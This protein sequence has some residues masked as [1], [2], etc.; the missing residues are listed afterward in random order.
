MLEE[1]KILLG[2]VIMNLFQSTALSI[3]SPFYPRIAQDKGIN[4]IMIG[5]IFAIAPFTRFLCSF[6]VGIILLKL[7]RKKAIIISTFIVAGSFIAFSLVI[8]IDDKVNFIVVSMI[9]RSLQ[10]VGMSFGMTASMA[11]VGSVFKEN[12]QKS[13]SIIETVNGLGNIIGPLIGALFYFIG[14]FMCPFMVGCIIIK[15]CAIFS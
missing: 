12:F 6:I 7:G 1:N 8:F 11:V 15:Y 4:H 14:G 9:I 3:I 2:L 5:L 13:V 10:G